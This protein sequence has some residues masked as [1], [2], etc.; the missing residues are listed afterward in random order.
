MQ[1]EEAKI[2]DRNIDSHVSMEL[3]E[4]TPAPC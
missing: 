1:H 3:M 4:E 2:L